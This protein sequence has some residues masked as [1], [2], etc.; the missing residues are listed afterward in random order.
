MPGGAEPRRSRAATERSTR[1]RRSRSW[2]SPRGRRRPFP[3]GR[4]PARAPSIH[5]REGTAMTTPKARPVE[6]ELK[7]RVR[8][9]AAIE[10]RLADDAIGSFVG[11][12]PVRTT[13]LED[14]Y[15]DTADGALGRAGFAV[16]LRQ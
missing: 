12:S 4:E 8:D 9:E 1:S 7:Y 16:R 10:H 14:R 13:Q 15:V 11:A 6:V 3:I 2:H 5:E